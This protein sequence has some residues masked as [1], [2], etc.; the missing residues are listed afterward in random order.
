MAI[1][2]LLGVVLAGAVAG[3]VSLMGASHARAGDTPCGKKGQPMCPLQEWMENELGAPM[4]KG[5]AKAVAEALTRVASLAPDPSWNEGEQG[6]AKIAQEGA[7]KAKAGDLKAA[8][9]SCKGCHSAW[10]KKYRA[11]HRPRVLPKAK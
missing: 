8:G 6:W 10:R 9:A 3:T 5:D 7:A 1:Q 2:R 4:E 11:E